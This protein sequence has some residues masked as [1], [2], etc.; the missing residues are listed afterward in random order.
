MMLSGRKPSV[1]DRLLAAPLGPCPNTTGRA[2]V[3]LN[4]VFHSGLSVPLS[5]LRAH[6]PYSAKPNLPGKNREILAME[7]AM[8]RQR[9]LERARECRELAETMSGENKKKL[10]RVAEAWEALAREDQA[11][12]VELSLKATAH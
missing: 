9:Y 3:F 4:L 5:H 11:D 7:D 1:G 10:L 12:E 6:Q 8:T 2:D